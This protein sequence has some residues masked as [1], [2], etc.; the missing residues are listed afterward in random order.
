MKSFYK[1]T[2]L[3]LSLPS[4]SIFLNQYF[5]AFH[6]RRKKGIRTHKANFPWML[7]ERK[8]N[9][10]TR[11]LRAADAGCAFGYLCVTLGNLLHFAET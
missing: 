10:E 3:V 8:Q 4:K 1:V 11:T 5:I 2:Q 7:E 9:S 6:A